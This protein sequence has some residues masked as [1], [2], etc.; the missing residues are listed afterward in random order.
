MHDEFYIGYEGP[1]PPGVARAVRGAIGVMLVTALAAAA[2]FALSQR[3]LADSRFE[4]GHVQPFEGWLS[5]APAPAL[6]VG[7]D[8]GWRRYWLVSQGKFGAER[9]L[10]ERSEGHVRLYGTLIAREPWQM[11]ELASRD[12]VDVPSEGARPIVAM[13]A[14]TLMRAH[15][16]VVDSKCFLGVMNPGERTVH[17][18]CAVRCLSGGIPSMF[19]FRDDNGRHHLALLIGPNGD[20]GGSTFLSHAGQPLELE[21]SLYAFGDAEVFVVAERSVAARSSDRPTS[22]LSSAAAASSSASSTGPIFRPYQ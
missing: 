17:R 8:N 15:G 1:M 3:P 5:R 6:L 22:S 19:S 7:S 10:G 13:S 11:I 12:I 14:P 20:A 2:T 21:G 18:D 16:E 4:Y 9:A